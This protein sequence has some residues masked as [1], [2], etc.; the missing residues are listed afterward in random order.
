VHPDLFVEQASEKKDPEKLMMLV[1]Q[2]CSAF[3][4]GKKPALPLERAGGMNSR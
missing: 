3:D 1:K 4:D 2:P